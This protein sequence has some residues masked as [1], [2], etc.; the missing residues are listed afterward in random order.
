[1]LPIFYFGATKLRTISFAYFPSA[2]LSVVT[3]GFIVMLIEDNFW[4][5]AKAL[6][7]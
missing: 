5:D 2:E 6:S 3:I 4:N 1:M 7:S